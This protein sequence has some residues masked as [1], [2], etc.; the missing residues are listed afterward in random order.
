[1]R[2]IAGTHHARAFLYARVSTRGQA[3]NGVSLD[4]QQ[5]EGRAFCR[6]EGYPD[7]E[8][9]I[10]VE[11]GGAE[12]LEQ[13]TELMRLLA[14]IRPGD[15]LVCYDLARWS[16]DQV[17]A[18]DSIR[19]LRDRGI[20]VRFW[21]QPFLDRKPPG[22]GGGGVPVDLTGI[23]AWAAE[24]E[25]HQTRDR[26]MSNRRA[27]RAGGAFVEGNPPFGYTVQDRKL[28][29]IPEYVPIVIRIFTDSLEGLSVRRIADALRVE[30][31]RI[32]VGREKK[33]VMT[34]TVNTVLKILRNR[35][36]TGYMETCAGGR[37]R[38][39]APGSGQWI[40]SHEA[41]ISPAVFDQVSRGLTA[42]QR[43]GRSVA[44]SLTAGYLLKGIAVCAVCGHKVRGLADRRVKGG[45][46]YQCAKRNDPTKYKD[47]T[48]CPNKTLAH[49]QETD[50]AAEALIIA[51]LDSLA[52]KLAAQTA[53]PQQPVPD[54]KR[55]AAEIAEARAKVVRLVVNGVITENDAATHLTELKRDE[56]ALEARRAEFERQAMNNTE[57]ARRAA[58]AKLTEY[59]EVWD[60]LSVSDRRELAAELAER[61]RVTTAGNVEIEWRPVAEV[62]GALGAPAVQ[63]AEMRAGLPAAA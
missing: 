57:E 36:Y 14:E 30:Y 1:M 16:R 50:A 6:A 40:N 17:F 43:A 45:G 11:S 53:P 12:K 37:K 27:L 29:P 38:R 39:D 13:R 61:I 44:T 56:E 60:R 41:I 18:V 42:R 9:R 54:W 3:D 55:L 5:C 7:P 49:W 24:N 51:R 10:E 52:S 58:F 34:W 33:H 62:S 19:K 26:S 4:T 23:I 15:V 46:Y 32:V 8:M 20:T 2:T 48:P 31:P 63:P 47:R 28:I 35:L 59:R 22:S 25:R 21:R